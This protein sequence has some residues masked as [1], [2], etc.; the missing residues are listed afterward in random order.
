MTDSDL[1]EPIR[2]KV[3]PVHY[4]MDWRCE[5]CIEYIRDHDNDNLFQRVPCAS[6]RMFGHHIPIVADF[7]EEEMKKKYPYV[8]THC[9]TCDCQI[10]LLNTPFYPSP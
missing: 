7:P 4:F 8:K 3:N 9:K 5:K 6:V 10:E 1:P 2:R